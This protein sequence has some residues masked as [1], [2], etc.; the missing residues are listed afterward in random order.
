MVAYHERYQDVSNFRVDRI[1][2]IEV[3]DEERYLT[4][5]TENFNVAEYTNKYFRM[6][7]GELERVKIQFDNSLI[8]V[9]IDRF[10]MD[11]NL[12]KINANYFTVDVDIVPS[13]TFFGWLFMFLGIKWKSV[14]PKV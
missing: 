8:N 11:V 9:V 5:D 6:Y 7:S 12:N 4:N 10:G 2:H 1:I 14:N 13:E 3:I